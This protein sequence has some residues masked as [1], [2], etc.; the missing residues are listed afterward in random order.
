MAVASPLVAPAAT[1][2]TQMFG[3]IRSVVLAYGRETFAFGWRDGS[4]PRDFA[5]QLRSAVRSATGLETLGSI[6]MQVEL[7]PGDVRAVIPRDLFEGRVPE[8]SVVRLA[9]VDDGG[10]GSSAGTPAAPP[11]AVG[12]ARCAPP[13]GGRPVVSGTAR[14]AGPAPLPASSAAARPPPDRKFQKKGGSQLQFVQMMAQNKPPAARL[15]PGLQLTMEEVK[16]HATPGDCWTVYRGKVYD[17]SMYMDFH[18]GGKKELMKGAGRDCT[19]LYDKIHP[20]VNA[21]GL[22]G[23]LCL[24]PLVP[25]T[26]GTSSA[27]NRHEEGARQDS[28]SE[29][30]VPPPRRGPS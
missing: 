22:I 9:L 6:E 30:E 8:G 14:V 2:G 16:R 25:D 20:W 15:P 11:R 23:S 26:G 7:T 4:L 27:R 28:D 18:P 24:G 1:A 19:E 13:S 3:S 17:V 29:D 5:A 12:A 10:A 21:D